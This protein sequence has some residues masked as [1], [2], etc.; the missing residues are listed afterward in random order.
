MLTPNSVSVQSVS[1]VTT[2]LI[3]YTTTI[4]TACY[5]FFDN[6]RLLNSLDKLI[7]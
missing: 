1:V 6:F 3:N 4:T 2:L 5:N 7:F